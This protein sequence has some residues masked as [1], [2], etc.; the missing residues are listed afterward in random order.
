MR[1][2]KPNPQNMRR[3]RYSKWLDGAVELLKESEEAFT[4]S[5]LINQLPDNR[6]TPPSANSAAQKMTK[7]PRFISTFDYT[8]DL[9]GHR[10]KTKFFSYNWGHV[11]EE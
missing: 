9:N 2:G 6:H 8:T 10:Y 4:A 3:R 7:D 1:H 5:Y 11:D